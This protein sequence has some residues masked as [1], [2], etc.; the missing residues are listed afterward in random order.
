MSD[1]TRRGWFCR[2]EEV[3]SRL[4]L[5]RLQ[6]VVCKG[7][8]LTNRGESL[9]PTVNESQGSEGFSVEYDLLSVLDSEVLINRIA[10][11]FSKSHFC[12]PVEP[13]FQ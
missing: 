10:L 2:I 8:N 11:S 7:L 5:K 13:R 9:E 3:I 4:K 12:L 1:Q 6:F